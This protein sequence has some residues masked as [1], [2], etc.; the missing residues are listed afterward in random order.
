MVSY[1]KDGITEHVK[2]HSPQLLS[3]PP[4]RGDERTIC[5]ELNRKL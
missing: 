5:D 3:T 2:T 1:G 4:P